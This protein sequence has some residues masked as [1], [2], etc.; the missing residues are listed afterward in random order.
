MTPQTRLTKRRR[1]AATVLFVSV[2]AYFLLA[3]MQGEAPSLT[4]RWLMSIPWVSGFVAVMCYS[5]GIRC[6]GCGK[7]LGRNDGGRT[8]S[9]FAHIERECP[10]CELDLAAP[11]GDER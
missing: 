4:M 2:A 1:A 10:R 8:L 5:W 9:P 3:I 11:N 6:P 7:R